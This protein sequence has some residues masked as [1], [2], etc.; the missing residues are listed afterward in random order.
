MTRLQSSNH[1]IAL[2]VQHFSVYKEVNEVIIIICIQAQC[3][4]NYIDHYTFNLLVIELV[5]KLCIELVLL[6]L[7]FRF[8]KYTFS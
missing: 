8:R 6:I 3:Y 1:T 4:T 7:V 5:L 2:S